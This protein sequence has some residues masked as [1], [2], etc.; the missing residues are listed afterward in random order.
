MRPTAAK[1]HFDPGIDKL[2]RSQFTESF[3]KCLIPNVLLPKLRIYLILL[4]FIRF[5]FQFH[6]VR[7]PTAFHIYHNGIH[8]MG[9]LLK[10]YLALDQSEAPQIGKNSL[11]D[12]PEWI[13]KMNLHW[14][15]AVVE[16]H[17]RACVFE[18]FPKWKAACI[19]AKGRPSHL[20]AGLS[21]DRA[22][23]PSLHI[24]LPQCGT[25]NQDESHSD[26]LRS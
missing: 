4:D 21:I 12:L 16:Y 15:P 18:K 26:S 14:Y 10:W 11:D 9:E 20:N 25:T 7:N 5:Y 19:I 22:R 24:S 6:K 1:V 23:S 13:F 8:Q 3:P 2:I 17:G